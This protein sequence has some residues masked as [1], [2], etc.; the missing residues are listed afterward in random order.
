MAY[1]F[2]SSA[3]GTRGPLSDVDVA[4]LLADDEDPLEA[5][6]RLMADI[7]AAIASD[8]VDVVVLNVAPEPLAFAVL[9]DGIVLVSRDDVA[10]V[11][12]RARVFD[13]YMDMEPFRRVQAEGLRHRLEEGR[14]G[15][16]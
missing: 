11:R 14:F 5:K 6:L 2:G 10:R 12:H 4:V 7:S 16:S 9:R 3:R 8:D 15:R 1:L 13:R